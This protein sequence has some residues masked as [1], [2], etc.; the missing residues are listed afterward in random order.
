MTRALLCVCTAGLVL[1][2]GCVAVP[3]TTVAVP[4]ATCQTVLRGNTQVVEI[5]SEP[6]GATV[7]IP[8]YEKRTTPAFFV[9]QR[10]RSYTVTL[11]KDGY[12]TAT[13]D[14]ASRRATDG[15]AGTVIGKAIDEASGAAWE[16][17]PDKLNV[18][19][20]ALGEPKAVATAPASSDP[21]SEPA[22]AVAAQT[23]TTPK[24]P[25]PTPQNG[26][27]VVTDQVA[28]LDKLLAD[29]VI[30]QREHDIL[31]ALAVSAT[32]VAGVPASQ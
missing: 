15:A 10:G 3:F 6:A 4:A 16:L 9:L 28:R 7:T 24:P 2:G 11:N 32:T 27:T 23:Q 19:L 8:G 1:L 13:A 5:R 29:G 25:T 20:V 18:A 17:N 30:S 21:K 22:P 14:L 26:S 12:K 31:V